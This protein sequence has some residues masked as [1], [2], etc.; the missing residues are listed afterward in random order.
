MRKLFL[1]IGLFAILS[2]AFISCDTNTKD[3]TV[4]PATAQSVLKN[5]FKSEI[6]NIEIDK[7]DGIIKEYEVKLA[8]GMKIEF[9]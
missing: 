6:S 1:A 5:D 3:V 7:K 4:L 2:I 8:N 9:D